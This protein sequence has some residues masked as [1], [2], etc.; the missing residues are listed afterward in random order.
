MPRTR[1]E[2]EA[3]ALSAVSYEDMDFSTITTGKGEALTRSRC[4]LCCTLACCCPY[5]DAGPGG[6]LQL[7]PSRISI[8][9]RKISTNTSTCCLSSTLR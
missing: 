3:I 5:T 8:L 9:W 7:L 4:A 2:M 6:W 1:A